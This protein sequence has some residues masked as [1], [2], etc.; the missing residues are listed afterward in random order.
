MVPAPSHF[1]IKDT[2]A[3]ILGHII[4]VFTLGTQHA[5]VYGVIRVAANMYISFA[6]LFN[7]DPASHPAI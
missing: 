3:C 7:K 4:E 6:I 2:V 5:F 1:R